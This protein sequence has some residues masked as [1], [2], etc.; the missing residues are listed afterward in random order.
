MT[1]PRRVSKNTASPSSCVIEQ[2]RD[3]RLEVGLGINPFVW[4]GNLNVVSNLERALLGSIIYPYLSAGRHRDI[5][6][7]FFLQ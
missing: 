7:V 6:R 5:N 4:Q 1:Y 2:E 3:N